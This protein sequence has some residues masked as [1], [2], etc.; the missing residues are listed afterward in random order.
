MEF[1]KF[2]P[3][4]FVDTSVKGTNKFWKLCGLIDRFNES[5]NHIDS[6]GGKTADESM[7]AMRFFTNPKG[8]LPHYSCFFMN[9]ETLRKYINN[10]VCLRLGT[11]LHLEIQKGEEVMKTSEFQ[12]YLGG[13]TVCMKRLAIATRGCG[14]LT[15]NDS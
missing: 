8:C 9:T 6:G 1:S 13:T 3:C 5:R 2:W 7:S 12:K 4:S 15:S 14:Q 11:V 10:M